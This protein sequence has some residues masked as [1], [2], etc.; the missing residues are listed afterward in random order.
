[1]MW[2]VRPMPSADLLAPQSSEELST[3]S[4]RSS[5]FNYLQENGRTYHALSQGS[6]LFIVLV[7]SIKCA[8]RYP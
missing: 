1:M 3:T 6:K 4:L 5:I 7:N 2:S 8:D